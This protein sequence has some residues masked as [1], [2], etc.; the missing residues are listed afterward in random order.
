M[1]NLILIILALKAI[2]RNKTRSFLTMLGI[3][4]GVA[5]VITMLA[6]GQGS[7]Q[8]IEQQVSE[9]GANMIMVFPGGG[10]RGGARLGASDMPQLTWNDVISIQNNSRNISHISPLVSGN[11]QAIAG[12]N[13]WPTSI[14]GVST[15][16]LTIRK[17]DISQGSLFTEYDINA[18]AKVCILGKTVINNLFKDGEQPLGQ[19]IR[20]NQIPFTVIGILKEKG[21]NTFGQDQDDV[22]IAPFTTV[23]KRI[24]GINHI[25]NIYLSAINE[26]SS[27]LAIE[28]VETVLRKKPKL[29]S[30]NTNKFEI[31]SQQE[32]LSMMGSTNQMMTLL[33]A[34]IAGISLLV[35]GI[36]IMN[37]MFVSVTERT[38]EIGLR[39]AV[40]GKERHILTQFLMEAIIVSIGGGLI[41]IFSGILA[42]VTLGKI[43]GW[44][45]IIT[46]SSII[47][48]F[49]VCAVIGVFFGWYP[50]RKA[51]SLDPI[52]ALRYE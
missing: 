13:N 9:M 15:D 18:A 19:I 23:Q 31:R 40:G 14:Q 1:R 16:Y 25:Q 12:A 20:Y 41:G 32:L 43:A 27:Q 30:G 8:S 50:A 7:K 52:E 36:G 2:S 11:G 26:E 24:L 10:Q 5:S 21:V 37:I 38:R 46:Q 47:L 22:I 49:F 45:M 3:I 39:M 17:L 42:S 6:I 34:A 4:I 51:A 28:E 29:V 44:P 33:L 48:S 35:G